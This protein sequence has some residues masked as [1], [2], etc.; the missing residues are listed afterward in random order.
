MSEKQILLVKYMFE[1]A[2]EVFDPNDPFACGLS[3]SLMQDS[4]EAMVWIVIKEYDAPFKPK[5]SFEQLWNSIPK[6]EQNKEKK[7]LPLRAKMVELNKARVN[8]KH[9]GNLPDATDATKFISYTEEFLREVARDFLHIDFE[10]ISY[11]DLIK[12][13]HIRN[14][15]KTA[16]EEYKKED[17]GQAL[18]ECADAEQIALSSLNRLFPTVDYNLKKAGNI[19][20]QTNSRGP[21]EIFNYISGYLESLRNV[22]VVN[23]AGVK[24]PEFLRFKSLIPKVHRSHSGK[25]QV[26]GRLYKLGEKEVV[27]CIKYVTDFVIKVQNNIG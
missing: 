20:S 6:A 26:T 23:L 16:E 4:I 2:S 1:K 8:F 5:D 14:I 7:E 17:W 27:F 18:I 19:F 9:Y 24:L 11:A 15:I 12:N 3:I 22:S 21:N 13:K 25:R 10:E